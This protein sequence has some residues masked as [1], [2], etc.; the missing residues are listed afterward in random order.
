[1]F[2]RCDAQVSTC[3]KVKKMLNEV[4]KKNPEQKIY[5]IDSY[6]NSQLTEY[7]NIALY[8]S[9]IFKKEKHEGIYN[10][11]RTVEEFSTFITKVNN[12]IVI[13]LESEND[14]INTFP[15]GDVVFILRNGKESLS[16]KYNNYNEK[17]KQLLLYEKLASKY[18]SIASFIQ[19]GELSE[20]STIE[21]LKIEVGKSLNRT[22]IYKETQ[23]TLE[24]FIQH[25][26]LSSIITVDSHNFK[27]IISLNKIL[28]CIVSNNKLQFQLFDLFIDLLNNEIKEHFI[29]GHLN[30]IIWKNYLTDHS[31]E[32]PSITIFNFEDNLLY[33]LKIDSKIIE[34]EN[35]FKKLLIN[36]IDKTISKELDFHDWEPLTYSM[37]IK[38]KF[39]NNYPFSLLIFLP[40]I[41]VL[42]VMTMSTYPDDK[43]LKK[44]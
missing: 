9:I 30:A 7:F 44:I 21:I 8:P 33:S 10:G 38:R 15:H 23:N 35:E 37:K 34:N 43:K 24:N 40:F 1:M 19:I 28:F 2:I 31:I 17:Q 39:W 36:L 26:S 5:S 25:N 6:D 42:F 27:H 13:K 4:I 32:S 16:I 11:K 12:E 22:I 18:I 3:G 14:I 20:D 29:F 41:V